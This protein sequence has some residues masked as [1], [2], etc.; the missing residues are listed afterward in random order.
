M[1]AVK[2]ADS[3]ACCTAMN[4][5]DP[6]RAVSEYTDTALCCVADGD[7]MWSLPCA[8]PGLLYG[9]LTGGLS[10]LGNADPGRCLSER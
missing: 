5:T 8:M 1:V 2:K 9:S 3:A 6:G 4:P 10:L 7:A